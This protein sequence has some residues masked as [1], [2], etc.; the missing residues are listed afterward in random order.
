NNQWI[1]AHPRSRCRQ[2]AALGGGIAPANDPAANEEQESPDSQLPP[3]PCEPPAASGGGGD[4]ESG[5]ALGFAGR[6][7]RMHPRWID[8][9]PCGARPR[10]R[11]TRQQGPRHS[12]RIAAPPDGAAPYCCATPSGAAR[13]AALVLRLAAPC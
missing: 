6:S 7:A 3:E 5:F 13:T 9:D 2:R 4:S 12:P 10:T 1:L 8:R 11:A